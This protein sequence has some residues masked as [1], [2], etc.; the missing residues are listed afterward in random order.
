MEKLQCGETST[1]L[2]SVATQ[3]NLLMKNKII[4]QGIFS[5]SIIKK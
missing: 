5:Q 2:A 3:G 1:T 4:L